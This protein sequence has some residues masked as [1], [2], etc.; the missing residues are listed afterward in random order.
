[1]GAGGVELD[2]Q[3]VERVGSGGRLEG[4]GGGLDGLEFFPWLDAVASLGMTRP[5]CGV[6]LVLAR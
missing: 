1:V 5:D 6:L 3:A 2:Q 4:A